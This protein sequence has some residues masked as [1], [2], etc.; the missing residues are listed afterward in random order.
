MANEE[1]VSGGIHLLLLIWYQLVVLGVYPC[2]EGQMSESC[3]GVNNI[4][5]RNTLKIVEAIEGILYFHDPVSIQNDMFSY[6]VVIEK[7]YKRY[8]LYFSGHL[9]D[10]I[11]IKWWWS[12]DISIQESTTNWY[13]FVQIVRARIII[14]V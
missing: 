2:Q 9:I 11:M 8:I 5:L 7:V 12:S 1:R 10:I 4:S 6:E 3:Y 14:Y 13:H